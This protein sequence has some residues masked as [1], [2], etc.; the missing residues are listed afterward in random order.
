MKLA[1]RYAF[2]AAL[3]VS[4]ACT[5]H[6]TDVPEL[7]GPS[8]F[9]R[10]IKVTATP[11]TIYQDGYSQSQVAIV[12]RGPDG[13]ALPNVT[14]AVQTAAGGAYQDF[15]MLSAR[16][17]VT[18]SEGRANVTYTAPPPPALL[19]SNG[20]LV[21]VVATP[22]GNDFETAVQESAD[23]RLLAPGIVLPPSSAPQSEFS[24]SPTPVNANVPA[25]FD[26]SRSCATQDPCS[27]TAGITDFVWNFG[28]GTSAV[29]QTT[30]HTFRS[31]GTYTVTLTV[32]NNRG[33]SASSSQSVTVQASAAPAANF[34]Y[35]PSGP[36]AGV[37][38]NFNGETSTAATGRRIVQ[39]YWNFGDGT[40]VQ[41]GSATTH[42][43]AA[44]GTYTVLLTVVDDAGQR[45]TSTGS[46]TVAP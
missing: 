21:T 19:G 16:T 10:S 35:S 18:N 7:T 5:V 44:A 8:E 6:G 31:D 20:S 2:L 32:T 41:T 37:A 39:Y 13:K 28:D 40:A 12:V 34:I 23:I 38:I 9:A 46:L 45:G 29:G 42:A 3:A 33:V 27:S 14:L 36:R 11:D 22:V 26:G 24:V 30:T 4:A 1:F 43:Y 17:V 15:G 25:N